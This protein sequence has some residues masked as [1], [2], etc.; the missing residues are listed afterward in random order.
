[1]QSEPIFEYKKIYL[2][3]IFI[4]GAPAIENLEIEEKNKKTNNNF[5]AIN[6]ESFYKPV[7][8]VISNEKVAYCS[9]KK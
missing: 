4:N 3:N 6:S 9:F 8:R 1:L 2:K 7:I 5:I